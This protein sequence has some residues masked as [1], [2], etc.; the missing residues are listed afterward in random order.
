MDKY[1]YKLKLEQLKNLINEGDYA[2]AGQIVDSINWRKVR[3]SATL[4]MVGDVY[5][6]LG[7]YDDSK[8][9]YLMAYDH[10]PIGRN[11]I[12]KLTEVAIKS[13]SLAEA[14]EYYNEYAEIA[15]NDTQKMVLRYKLSTMKNEPIQN[16]ISI[17]EELKEREYT[18]EWAY[19]LA[20]LYQEAGKTRE[21]VDV[22]DELELWF[23][24]GEY[25]EKALELK[26]HYE[27]LTK[28]Q[29]EKFRRFRQK[30]EEVIVPVP[31]P[32]DTKGNVAD[33]LTGVKEPVEN[34]HKFDTVNLQAEL[35]K[36]MKQIMDAKEQ[37]EVSDTMDSIMKMVEDIPQL[38]KEIEE[39]VGM[40]INEEMLNEKIDEA[41]ADD[42]QEFLEEEPDGQIS[43]DVPT[44]P[45][46][47]DQITGQLN[48]E[49][50]LAEWEKT[51]RAAEAA[52][53][54]AEQKKLEV[55]KLK[56]IQ[57]AQEL[58]QKLENLS[59]ELQD[60]TTPKE[61][62]EQEYLAG[63]EE[64]PAASET[65]EVPAEEALPE[66][67][68]EETPVEEVVLEEPVEETPVEE[69][70]PE[71]PA[72]EN[73]TD[74]DIESTLIFPDITQFLKEDA[75]EL[76]EAEPVTEAVQSNPEPE[77]PV[78]AEPVQETPDKAP[79]AEPTDADI[80]AML[81]MPDIAD[82]FGEETAVSA[83]QQ[84]AVPEIEEPEIMPEAPA[85]EPEK[86]LTEEME[87]PAVIKE[88]EEEPAEAEEESSE[89]ADEFYQNVLDDAH[90]ILL[91]EIDR[92]AKAAA[93]IDEILN[94]PIDEPEEIPAEEM[95]AEAEEAPAEEDIDAQLVMPD[96]TGLMEEAEEE[97]V[98]EPAAKAEV[99]AEEVPEE[100]P[101]AVV[102]PEELFAETKQSIVDEIPLPEDIMADIVQKETT[103]A[104][105]VLTKEQRALFPYFLPVPG[106]EAQICQVLKACVAK[107]KTI[108]SLT[109]NITIE[110]PDG[111]GKTV[112]AASLIK[113]LQM[114][115]EDAEGRT[116][117][118]SA[119]AL[120]KKDFAA[121]LPKL[122]GGYLI[123]E[124]A[125]NLLPETIEKISRA[126][127]GNTQGLTVIMEDSKS[128]IRAVL[129]KNR[130]FAQKFTSNITIPVFTID[131]LV[132]FGKSYARE[133][134]CTIDEMGILALY[135]RIS[136]IQKHDKAT[137]LTEVREIVDQAIE[138]AESG[139]GIKKTFGS[140]FTKR[141]NDNDFLILHEKDF[142]I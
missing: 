35:Q 37:D 75:S 136:N 70:I 106:M 10:A 34:P 140:F 59:P 43:L 61:L 135:N 101:S 91:E 90:K 32:E 21:C 51:K 105:V 45:L 1:E 81:V 56:A 112:L 13:N 42:F 142:D 25:V 89:D 53:A 125:G 52:L 67:P 3:N 117:K 103:T 123:I 65:T 88:S 57:E 9:I 86:V 133:M 134:E 127:E 58:I 78:A 7:R 54:V 98:M 102:A 126:M 6:K 18:E 130:G 2:T 80:D 132:D 74:E 11:I 5:D 87:E 114:M 76:P 107:K 4:C 60:G 110:G 17:L 47:D 119:T 120:N 64:E 128:R 19:E 24:E 77:V 138:S 116:G 63:G 66:E 12:Y 62:L 93:G 129:S 44:S 49:D 31:V 48:I 115:T 84:P 27:P 111:S 137:T 85:D 83:E 15:G 131:E 97:P 29:E 139:G 55:A 99:P 16:R 40:K 72:E 109:G 122:Q 68:V 50:V 79:T 104:D 73:S 108:T 113:A 41:V 100:I 92:I 121:L 71:V 38:K 141:Y 118:I 22:C 94:G 95:P 8:E 26:M 96:I 39:P 82:L 23:G 124:K 46:L 28:T 33:I 30:R 36:S 20:R 69:V 14:E